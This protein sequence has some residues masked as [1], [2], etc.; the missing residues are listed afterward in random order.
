MWTWRRRPRPSDPASD[1][2]DVEAFLL[3]GSVEYF[4]AHHQAVPPWAWLNTVAH[5]PPVAVDDL[6]FH[7]PRPEGSKAEAAGRRAV[8]TIA[9][10]LCVQTKGDPTAIG[11]LQCEVLI[12]LELA[13]V[14]GRIHASDARGVVQLAVAALQARRRP[15]S[16]IEDPDHR[17]R[18]R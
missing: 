13:L 15:P 11:A 17:G 14:A 9:H 2:A 8:E 3:G 6:R 1:V 18:P 12:P 10:A 4:R 5:S 7:A 16:G